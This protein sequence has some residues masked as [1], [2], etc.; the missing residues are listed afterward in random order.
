M[1]PSGS[2]PAPAGRIEASRNANDSPIAKP[3]NVIPAKT[4]ASR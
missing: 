1:S 3:A 2:S 4:R